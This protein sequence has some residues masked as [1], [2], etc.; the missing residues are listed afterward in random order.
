MVIYIKLIAIG[1]TCLLTYCANAQILTR[2]GSPL[3]TRIS[4]TIGNNIPAPVYNIVLAFHG[5]SITRDVIS[6]GQERS[7]FCFVVYNSV[8]NISGLFPSFTQ[9]GINGISYNYRWPSEPYIATLTEDALNV[10]DLVKQTGSS[11]NWLV[12][13]AGTNGIVLQGNTGAVE[14]ANFKTYIAARVSA[15]WIPTNIVVITMLPRTGL[16][17]VSRGIFNTS[18]VGDDGGYGYKLARVDLNADIGLAGDNLNTVYFYDG[19]HPTAA[20][21]AIIAS[22]VYAV[23]YP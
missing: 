7:N 3:Q 1:L 23:M 16:S 13:F 22:I 14:Y 6:A 20:G 9:R 5:D 17:E 15:G 4:M 12:V 21:H 10:L 11:T 18:V 2:T 19:T 8:S